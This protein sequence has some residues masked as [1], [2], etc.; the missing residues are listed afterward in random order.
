[1]RAL[2]IQQP[3]AWLIARGYKPIENRNWSTDFRGRFL[4][5]AGQRIDREGYAWVREHFPEIPLPALEDFQRG[6]F[7]GSATL[8]DVVTEHESPWFQG[9]K[10]FVLGG[11]QPLPFMPHKGALY[12]F[13]V[14]GSS[15]Q[16]AK[17]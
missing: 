8:V 10:G 9:P 14:Q 7:V 11:A 16:W 15:F 3:W 4:I 2:S 13:E 12:F 6:G 5:H 1:M 17:A